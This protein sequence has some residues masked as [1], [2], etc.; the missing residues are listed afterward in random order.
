MLNLITRQ[1]A[2]GYVD[3]PASVQLLDEMVDRWFNQPAAA[4]PW[5]PAVDVIENDQELVLSADLPGIKMENVEVKI[6][7]GTLTLS[8]SR[9]F[10]SESKK[11]GYH[12]LER[13]FGSFRRAFSLPDSVDVEKVQAAMKDGVLTVRLPKKDIARPRTVKVEVS[14]S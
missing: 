10:E 13:S 8:G 7:D 4:R 1:P 5:A 2:Q 11:D 12:R 6:E 3:F 14:A 9:K